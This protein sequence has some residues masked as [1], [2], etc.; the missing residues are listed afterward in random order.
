MTRRYLGTW[1]LPSGNS[2]DVYIASDRLEC[3]WQRPPSP[4]WSDADVEHWRTATF[5]AIVRAAA[6]ATGQSVLG[7]TA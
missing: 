6:T 3:R 2:A 4:A 5:P 1:T 7:V